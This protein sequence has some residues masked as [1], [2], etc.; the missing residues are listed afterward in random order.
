MA[1]RYCGVK[2]IFGCGRILALRSFEVIPGMR[3]LVDV[4]LPDEFDMPIVCPVCNDG[5]LYTQD[6][7]MYFDEL[8]LIAKGFERYV[9][10]T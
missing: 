9:L 2:C 8:D 7:R 5:T 6:R 3:E 1:K 4:T 10:E